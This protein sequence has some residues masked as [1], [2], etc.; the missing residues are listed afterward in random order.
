MQYFYSIVRSDKLKYQK[1]D[2]DG[3]KFDLGPL[4]ENGGW[5]YS[6]LQQ[7][8]DALKHGAEFGEYIIFKF[9]FNPTVK[10]LQDMC[11]FACGNNVRPLNF[12]VNVVE[13][14]SIFV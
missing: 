2:G 4:M 3:L 5:V 14:I 1:I 10:N 9:S 7:A 11:S 13:T 12:E 6:N 8:Y